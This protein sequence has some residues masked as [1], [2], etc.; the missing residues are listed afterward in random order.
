MI[1]A[2]V[3]LLLCVCLS[4]SVNADYFWL[5]AGIHGVAA[6]V[7][8]FYSARKRVPARRAINIASVATLVVN[9]CYCYAKLN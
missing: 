2:I 1:I 6:S 9:A 3:L 8:L 4:L 5:I 7:A